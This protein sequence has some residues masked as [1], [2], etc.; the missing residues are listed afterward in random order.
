LTVGN[1]V[2]QLDIPLC[3]VVLVVEPELY[4]MYNKDTHIELISVVLE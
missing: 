2:L 3:G 4:M 1:A